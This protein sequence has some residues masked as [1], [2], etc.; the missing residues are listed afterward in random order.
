MKVTKSTEKIP[1]FSDELGFLYPLAWRILSSSRVWSPAMWLPRKSGLAIDIYICVWWT[2]EVALALVCSLLFSWR[3]GVVWLCVGLLLFRLLDIGFVLFSIL[4][5][6]FYRRE[7][8]WLSANRLVLLVLA[9]ALEMMF[10]YAVLYRA[11]GVVASGAAAIMPPLGSLFD[12]FYFSVVTATTLGYGTPH[13]TAWVSRTLS[14][15]ETLTMVLIVVT[16]VGYIAGARPIPRD[17][18]KDKSQTETNN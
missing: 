12:S 10:V 16:L 5:K 1:H 2:L 9:N 6:G 17:I 18:E 7:G 4:L 14:I 15:V 11:L 3:G 13:P 8:D